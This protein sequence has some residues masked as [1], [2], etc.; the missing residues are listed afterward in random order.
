MNTKKDSFLKNH[1]CKI[2]IDDLFLRLLGFK[3]VLITA[4]QA[5]LTREALK[6]NMETTLGNLR[7]WAKDE[8]AEHEVV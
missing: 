7:N 6:E 3:N 5:F 1:S 4:H 2:M 8:E